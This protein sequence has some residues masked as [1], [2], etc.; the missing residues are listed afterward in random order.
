MSEYA[1]M[2]SVKVQGENN[3][4][5]ILE[6]GEIKP[7]REIKGMSITITGNN[8]EILI[9]LPS[10]F[11]NTA[12]VMNGDENYCAIKATR[13]RYVRHTTFGMENGGKITFGGGISV[14][15][16]LNVVAKAGKRVDIGDECMFARDI[17]VRNDDG[18][19]IIDAT[20]KDIINAPENI[21]IADKVW[22]GT[23]AM[24]LKGSE[25][26]EGSVV[27]AM[28]LVNKKFTEKNIII[29][30]VPAKKVR[31]NIIWDRSDYYT[32]CEKLC[33]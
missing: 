27:G 15:R 33:D 21:K 26:P 30:G 6:N 19:T 28:S 11:I 8:N 16:N 20:T 22:V 29:A 32:Y 18:H 10:K 1:D 5:Q 4:I 24:I 25:I 14:Y 31:E 12:I 9:E 2:S 23:R 17:I 7:Y 3:K 13:H